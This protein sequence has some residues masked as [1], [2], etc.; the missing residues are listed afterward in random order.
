MGKRSSEET[1]Q[2]QAVWTQ[3][4][5]AVKVPME[6]LVPDLSKITKAER[7]WFLYIYSHLALKP[8]QTQTHIYRQGPL[9]KDKMTIF[10]G[11]KHAL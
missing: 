7:K 5:N 8:F 1:A 9:L 4:G 6:S 2:R 3:G 11:S 10:A